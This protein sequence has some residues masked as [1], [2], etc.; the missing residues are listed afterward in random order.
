V[1]IAAIALAVAWIG[2]PRRAASLTSP[3]HRHGWWQC[4]HCDWAYRPVPA[5]PPRGRSNAGGRLQEDPTTLAGMGYRVPASHDPH[6]RPSLPLTDP[7]STVGFQLRARRAK[8]TDAEGR[9]GS[10]QIPFCMTQPIR[11]IRRATSLI[12]PLRRVP[13]SHPAGGFWWSQKFCRLHRPSRHWRS[14]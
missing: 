13:V 12:S 1:N 3:P 9:S 4:A 6:Q 2:R 7:R 11:I 5:P 10:S 8:Y 14:V